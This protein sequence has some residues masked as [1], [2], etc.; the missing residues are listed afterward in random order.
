MDKQFDC[1]EMK[2]QAQD[3]I[4]EKLRGMTKEQELAYWAEQ[5]KRLADSRAAGDRKKSA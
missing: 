3:R 1:V 4:R 5:S 2:R